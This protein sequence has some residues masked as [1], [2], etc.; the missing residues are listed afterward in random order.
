MQKWMSHQVSGTAFTAAA[1]KR[2]D[3]LSNPIKTKAIVPT[4]DTLLFIKKQQGN[5]SKSLS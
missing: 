5:S 3:V 2:F 4:K 1:K